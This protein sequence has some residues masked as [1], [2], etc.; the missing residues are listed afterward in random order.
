MLR[1]GHELTFVRYRERWDKSIR[2][3]RRDVALLRDAGFIIGT[4]RHSTRGN[5]R[6]VFDGFTPEY[7]G[8]E[9]VAL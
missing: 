3:F 8:P 7:G 6:Y 2:S 5:P 1:H 4:T 9:R